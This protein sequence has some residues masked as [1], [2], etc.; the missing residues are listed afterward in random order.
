ME[1]ASKEAGQAAYDAEF[2]AHISH[3][4]SAEADDLT[5]LSTC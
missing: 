2:T 3:S 4:S 5:M 1:K